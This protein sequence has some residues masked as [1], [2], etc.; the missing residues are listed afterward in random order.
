MKTPIKY[1][2]L[3]KNGKITTQILGEVLY[4][5]NKRA[6]NWRDKK[7]EYKSLIYDKYNNY[8]KALE[9]E[10]YY[11]GMKENILNKLQPIAIHKEIIINE[12]IRKIYDYEEEYF[13]INDNK[14]ISKSEYFDKEVCDYIQFKRVR[15]KTEKELYY[16]FYEVSEY[17]F[18]KPIN[19]SDINKYKLK[20]VEL[21]N[22]ITYGKDI[23]DLLS[24]QFCNKV[25]DLFIND[26][27]KLIK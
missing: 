10:Q 7:R 22:F 11:Y 5:I 9:Q 20:V 16:L 2:A 1:N 14:V 3:I 17:T 6:K 26:K 12:Y 18:H 13:S 21:D 24:T 27:L 23:S 8:D 25:Y 15:E 4:S 19:K